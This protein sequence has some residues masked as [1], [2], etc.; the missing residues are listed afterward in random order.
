MENILE[1]YESDADSDRSS[2]NKSQEIKDEAATVCRT[3]SGDSVS[4]IDDKDYLN[5][6]KAIEDNLLN[7]LNNDSDAGGSGDGGRHD[8][9]DDDNERKS[10]SLSFDEDIIF[11]EQRRESE[12][13]QKERD[14]MKRKEIKTKKEIEEEERE[15][16][17]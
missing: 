4:D 6:A 7:M 8:D 2:L 10:V 12:H 5:A 16:M 1:H 15:K 17:Q 9:I 14:R 3:P 13:E 11:P